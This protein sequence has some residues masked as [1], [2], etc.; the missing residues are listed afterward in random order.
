MLKLKLYCNNI[1]SLIF[2]NASVQEIPL[3]FE[4]ENQPVILSDDDYEAIFKLMPSI[5]SLI[6]ADTQC[7]YNEYLNCLF[8]FYALRKLLNDLNVSSPILNTYFET[9]KNYKEK[10]F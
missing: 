8:D 1:L 4:K 6:N 3:S 5:L 10:I 9:I 7:I 2:I